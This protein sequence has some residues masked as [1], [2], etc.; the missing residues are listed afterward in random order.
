VGI[1]KA[2]NELKFE[3]VKG[4]QIP[5]AMRYIIRRTHTED[6]TDIRREVPNLDSQLEKPGDGL[7]R[8]VEVSYSPVRS[9]I[10]QFSTKKN[11]T[12][13]TW[14]CPCIEV[15]AENEEGLFTLVEKFNVQKP[16]HLLD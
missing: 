9:A 16:S 1:K 12:S 11:G 3:T 6:L 8:F 4:Y 5:M 14:V 13:W 10:Y 7:R 2:V 15:V